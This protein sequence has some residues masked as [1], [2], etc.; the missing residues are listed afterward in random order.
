M[1]RPPVLIIVAAVLLAGVGV[2]WAARPDSEPQSE[3]RVEV[4]A[5]PAVDRSVPAEPDVSS[6]D[7]ASAVDADRAQTRDIDVV[8]DVSDE[9]RSAVTTDPSPA[10]LEEQSAAAAVTP[11]QVVTTTTTI[12]PPPTTAA[13][14]PAVAFT[15]TQ[16]YGSCDEPIPYDIFSGTADPG[17]TVTISSPYGSGSAVADGAGHWERKVEFPSAPRGETFAVIASGVGGSKTLNFTAGS[18]GGH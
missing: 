8:V 16:A 5:A 4:S 3:S 12:P 18:G 6:I 10:H 15:A 13:A 2:G 9:T 1:R 11:I 7:R 14:K 17:S